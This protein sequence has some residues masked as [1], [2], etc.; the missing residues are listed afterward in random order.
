MVHYLVTMNLDVDTF[1]S[2]DADSIIWW[3]RMKKTQAIHHCII[4]DVSLI[5]LSI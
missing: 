5:A 4:Y 2:S 1:I 3:R